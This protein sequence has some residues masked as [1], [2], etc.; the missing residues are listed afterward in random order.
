MSVTKCALLQSTMKEY[1]RLVAAL[2]SLPALPA[3]KLNRASEGPAQRRVALV[4][5]LRA[6]FDR[7]CEDFDLFCDMPTEWASQGTA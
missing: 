5:Q 1:K 6:V 7:A 3:G 4:E 2:R